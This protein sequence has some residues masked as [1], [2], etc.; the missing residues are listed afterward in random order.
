MLSLRFVNDL[1]KTLLACLQHLQWRVQ[2]GADSV[3]QWTAPESLRRFYPGGLYGH[4][5]F[6]R[7]IWI[8]PLGFADV[9]GGSCSFKPHVQ[10]ILCS[11]KFWYIG[12]SSSVMAVVNITNKMYLCLLVLM[13][14]LHF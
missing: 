6:G 13:L 1:I 8:E 14:V 10:Y 12:I 9:R 7:P 4:D 3:L 11:G 5:K 2:V